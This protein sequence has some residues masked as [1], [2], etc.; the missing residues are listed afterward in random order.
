M[1]SDESDMRKIIRQTE[2]IFLLEGF[3]PTAQKRAIDEA[4]L[5]GKVT[6]AEAIAEMNSYVRE[7]KT[8]EG[9]IESRPWAN[10]QVG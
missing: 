1:N 7:K 3:K 10:G 4:I 9:F 2:A 6:Y 8:L 5:A